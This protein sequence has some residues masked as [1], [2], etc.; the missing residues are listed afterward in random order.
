MQVRVIL[1][2]GAAQAAGGVRECAMGCDEETLSVGALVDA[3][4]MQFKGLESMLP[5]CAVAVNRQYAG[6]GT[7]L[8]DGDEV[9]LIPPV[10]G[11]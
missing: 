9:A 10:S 3:I 6:R 7:I 8:R 1:F 4:G 2:A 5:N 11:G